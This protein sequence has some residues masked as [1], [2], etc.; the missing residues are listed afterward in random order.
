MAPTRTVVIQK[1]VC[2]PGPFARTERRGL[3]WALPMESSANRED[4]L[5]SLGSPLPSLNQSALVM[6]RPR[7]SEVSYRPQRRAPPTFAEC[8]APKI[9]GPCA[10]L[11]SHIGS[12]PH[13]SPRASHKRLSRCW[14]ASTARSM[15]TLRTPTTASASTSSANSRM[16]WAYQ[17]GSSSTT[18]LSSRGQTPRS[19]SRHPTTPLNRAAADDSGHVG[20]AL[21]G[22]ASRRSGVRRLKTVGSAF[23]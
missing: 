18:R 14:R 1:I 22:R 10:G 12:A 16:P 3:P 2:L 8:Q 20:V 5:A 11:G 9:F 17:C 6:P 23:G 7:L 15:S 4:S 19:D 13:A 21:G